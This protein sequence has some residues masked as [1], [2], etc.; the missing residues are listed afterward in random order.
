MAE[1]LGALV[2]LALLAGI[3]LWLIL[4]ALA[5]AYRILRDGL[6]MA[7]AGV[8]AFVSCAA[9]ALSVLLVVVVALCVF[10]LGITAAKKTNDQVAALARKTPGWAIPLLAAAT[11]GL[12]SMSRSIMPGHGQVAGSLFAVGLGCIVAISS[13]LA[14]QQEKTLRVLGFVLAF[15]PFA[16]VAAFIFVPGGDSYILNWK[17]IDCVAAIGTVL[18]V[19]IC[20]VI[21]HH[22]HRAAQAD[23][24]PA[25]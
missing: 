6:A 1:F 25:A 11:S 24:D 20:L 7:R 23:A 14:A 13:I 5:L 10:W 12:V 17:P 21:A 16:V 15:L 2:L 19:V 22:L 4:P 9:A 8:S 3:V 18:C